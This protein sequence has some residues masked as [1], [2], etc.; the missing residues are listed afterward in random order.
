MTSTPRW[1]WP[2]PQIDD[3][4]PTVLL[5]RTDA[6]RPALGYRTAR[7]LPRFV[8][9]LA[10]HDGT[11]TYAGKVAATCQVCLDHA[12]GWTTRYTNLEHM[13]AT[14]T[15]RDGRARR[16][17]VRAGD[18]LGYVTRPHELGFELWRRGEP[19]VD[20][21]VLRELMHAWVALRWTEYPDQRVAS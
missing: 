19:S 5:D 4:R 13:L 7:T 12:H 15:D 18:V 3:L 14:P 1:T 2:L 20:S 21:T 8:P 11:I 10:A 17:R 6:R 9:V 16:A